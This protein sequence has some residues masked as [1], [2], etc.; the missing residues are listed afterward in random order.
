MNPLIKIDHRA[1]PTGLRATLCTLALQ[2]EGVHSSHRELA[3]YSVS[4]IGL[5]GRILVAKG[6]LFSAQITPREARYF[7]T[8]ANRDKYAA[9]HTR[10]RPVALT[11]RKVM[12]RAPWCGTDQEDCEP[13]Y[14]D[15]TVYTP[16][17]SFTP[18][19]AEQTFAFVH[20]GLRCA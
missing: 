12:S 15:T 4:S 20:G 1:K 2:P 11:I 19:N 14:T 5:Q 8:A 16:C 3:G 13:V 10:R 17:P 9:G 6:T 18:R 7:A